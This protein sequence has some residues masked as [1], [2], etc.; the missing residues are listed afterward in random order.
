M[1]RVGG[2]KKADKVVD[3]EQR[4]WQP[5]DTFYCQLVESRALSH[6]IR[7]KQSFAKLLLYSSHKNFHYQ[8]AQG[9][10]A[11]VSISVN[12][13]QTQQQKCMLIKMKP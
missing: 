3:K 1:G 6:D 4:L 10:Q 7:L 8:P 5:M 12:L 2:Q 11:A 13:C 9:E